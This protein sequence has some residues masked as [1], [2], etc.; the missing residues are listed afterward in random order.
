MPIGLPNCSR[1]F[2]YSIASS[3]AFAP[4]PTASSESAA[5]CSFSGPRRLEELLAAVGAPRL[6]VQHGAV[7]EAELG[8]LVL[9]PAAVRHDVARLSPQ[10]LLV[11]RERE[12]HQRPLGRPSTRSA[13]MLRRI[14]DVP[15]SIVLPRERSCW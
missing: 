2:A 10:R 5:S 8:D 3:S 11:F 1:V 7:E 13:M 15:A 6:L 14:S 9:A 12:L 4:I